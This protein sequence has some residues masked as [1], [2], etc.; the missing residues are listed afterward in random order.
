[1]RPTN[2]PKQALT[3]MALSRRGMARVKK[4]LYYINIGIFAHKFSHFTLL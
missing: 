1:M 3:T 4:A 2:A